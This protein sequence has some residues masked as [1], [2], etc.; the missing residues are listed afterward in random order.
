MKTAYLNNRFYRTKIY[1]Y[2]HIIMTRYNKTKTTDIEVSSQTVSVALWPWF[3]E[4]L[5]LCWSQLLKVSVSPSPKW[6]TVNSLWEVT[7]QQKINKR[8]HTLNKAQVASLV[9]TSRGALRLSALLQT[10]DLFKFWLNSLYKGQGCHQPVV[11]THCQQNTHILRIQPFSTWKECGAG[12]LELLHLGPL[13]ED[14][15]MLRLSDGWI[16]IAI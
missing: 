11:Y 12:T 15:P 8:I 2:L 6:T 1:I 9:G 4:F 3:M 10:V 5:S 13:M 16:W 14:W 7:D